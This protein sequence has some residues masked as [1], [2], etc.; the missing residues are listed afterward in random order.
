M[1]VW[2]VL[3]CLLL[4]SAPLQAEEQPVLQWCLDNYPNRHNYPPQGEPYGPT[5]DLMRELARRS[6]F[7]LT[8]SPNTPFARCLKL[9]HDGSTDLM[10]R[11]NYSD[12]RNSYMHLIPYV[13]AARAEYLYLLEQHKDIRN[14]AQL[15]GLTIGVIRGYI[16][17]AELPNLLIQNSKNVVEID[18]EDS[19]MTMLLYQRV[20]AVIAPMQTTEHVINS[21]PK[22]K[23][24]IK[25]ASLIFPFQHN[26]YVHIGL[27]RKSRHAALLPQIQDAINS[28]EQDGLIQHYYQQDAAVNSA[29]SKA[30]DQS[31]SAGNTLKDG[32][33]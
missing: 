12:E 5:V 29:D 27:S 28:M 22:F 31:A 24:S 9:M 14:M 15:R 2:L 32:G 26:M 20:D 3:S 21:N 10:I 33:D 7:V 4:L 16:Y 11:L 23:D 19:A 6:G 17:N 8:F 30:N 25:I 18:T 13:Q 1:K